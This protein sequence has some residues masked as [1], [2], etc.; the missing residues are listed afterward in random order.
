MKYPNKA[1]F[2]TPHPQWTDLLDH[3]VHDAINLTF[4]KV[5]LDHLNTEHDP[6][7]V[8]SILLASMLHHSRWIIEI[9]ESHPNHPFSKIPLMS[10]PLLGELIE[11]CLTM[12]LSE[13]ILRVSG[14]PPH[15]EH[16]CRIEE[17]K[18]ISLGLKEDIQDFAW[19]CVIWSVMQLTR[20]SGQREELTPVF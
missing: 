2:A 8:L 13:H 10:S 5:L 17:V 3:R 1:D 18:Q 4:S 11:H 16:L 14:I 15:I 19:T 12:E 6:Y 20:R 7:G 9:I